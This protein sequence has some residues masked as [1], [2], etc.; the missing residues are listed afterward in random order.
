MSKLDKFRLF[1]TFKF[2]YVAT[3]DIGHINVT[4]LFGPVSI[5]SLKI[6]SF[7][8]ARSARPHSH[9]SRDTMSTYCIFSFT[10]VVHFKSLLK[11][12]LLFL[13]FNNDIKYSL[14]STIC[15]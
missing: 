10:W 2:T 4:Y 14:E 13:I 5:K 6:R 12:T 9:T 15:R 3:L 8:E 1:K 11:V 7:G